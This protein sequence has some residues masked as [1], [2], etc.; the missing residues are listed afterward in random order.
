[1]SSDKGLAH[2]WTGVSHLPPLWDGD[3]GRGTRE[4][5]VALATTSKRIK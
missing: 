5:M 3:E 1:M 4:K 2:S